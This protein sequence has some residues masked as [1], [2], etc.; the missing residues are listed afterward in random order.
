MCSASKEGLDLAIEFRKKHTLGN[1]PIADIAGFMQLVNADFMILDLPAN[2]D[3]LALRDPVTG[4]TVIGIAKSSV[5][6]R[7]RFTVAHEIGHFVSNDFESS[8]IVA[9]DE[10]SEPGIYACGKRDYQEVRADAFARNVLC[11]TDGLKTDQN[12]RE[13]IGGGDVLAALSHVVRKYQISPRVALI[14]MRRADLISE[15]QSEEL[16]GVSAPTLAARYGWKADYDRA[17]KVSELVQPSA[18]LVKD[19]YR[20]YE[21]GIVDLPSIAFAEMSSVDEVKE[22]ISASQSQLP[23]L[24]H[25]ANV[26]NQ[27]AADTEA[28]PFAE[29]D[30]FFGDGPDSLES[31]Q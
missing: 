30:A 18:R 8:K 21:Q 17:V 12:L 5:P 15:G 16:K 28:D 29:L 2:V 11:P 9:D 25:D 13:L 31:A 24:R 3:A 22:L 14:Q 27:D 19:V 20:A 1:D 10:H 6:Y 26:Q 23:P 7:Q 4:A